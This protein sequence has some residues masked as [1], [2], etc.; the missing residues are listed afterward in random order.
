MEVGKVQGTLEEKER[1]GT[2]EERGED[3]TECSDFSAKC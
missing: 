1:E 2:G 3:K